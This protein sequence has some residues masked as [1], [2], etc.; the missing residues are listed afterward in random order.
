[1]SILSACC[2]YPQQL[3]N[4]S[5]NNE[6]IVILVQKIVFSILCNRNLEFSFSR[7]NSSTHPTLGLAQDTNFFQKLVE[8][9]GLEPL[10]SS[11]QSWRSTN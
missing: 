6:L 3:L 8:A 4:M 2:S 1:M 5:K 9:R 11:L 10:T 7:L